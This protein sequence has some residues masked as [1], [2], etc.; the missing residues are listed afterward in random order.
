MIHKMKLNPSEFQKIRNGQKTIEV[1]LFDKKRQE[2][3]V[4]DK[5]IFSLL[6]DSEQ[7]LETEVTELLKFKTFSDLFSSFP[8]EQFGGNDTEE[9][10]NNIYKYYKHEDELKCGVLGIRVKLI[11]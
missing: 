2:V 6:E 9:L 4:D 10:L 1:R 3:R 5:I 11:N 8:K 7:K